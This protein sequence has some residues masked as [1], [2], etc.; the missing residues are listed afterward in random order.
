MLARA[1]CNGYWIGITLP[2]QAAQLR[3]QYDL[4]RSSTMDD[5][6][7]K[8]HALSRRSLLKAGASAAGMAAVGL[9]PEAF[10]QSGFDWKRFK[11]E[12]LEVSLTLG[13][14]GELLQ[15]NRKEF[16][17]LTGMTVGDEQ[18]PEQQHRQKVA[19]EFTSGN[20]SFDVVTM[21]Y[22]VQKQLYGRGKWLVDIRD[23]VKDAKLTNP[24]F[25][26]A[27]YAKGAM[28]Y[29]TQKDGRLDTLPLNLDYF[30]I[31]WNKEL[32]AA[33]GVAYPKSFPEIIEAARKLNDP[34]KGIAGWV[35]RG[36]KNANL[37]PYL[38]FL[39]GYG[40]D[41]IDPDLTMHMDGPES[42][43]VAKIYQQLNREF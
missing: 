30:V 10:A 13:P 9:A 32:F 39:L 6:D 11:G 40:V 38:T 31:Y 15:K 37:P 14:R 42:V 5:R 35:M 33:K 7:Q 3:D 25:D 28:D 21:A 36:L 1:F 20:T 16:E 24:E 34:Q 29:A 12:H 18:V 2:P 19:I 26:F 23:Y 8:R 41:S 22:H 43:D 27:D 17:E 4:G